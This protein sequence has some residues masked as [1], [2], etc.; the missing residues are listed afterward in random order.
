MKDFERHSSAM[1]KRLADY[2]AEHHIA[3]E[4]SALLLVREVGNGE[5]VGATCR[6]AIEGED[7]IV[8]IQT[9]HYAAKILTEELRKVAQT[10]NLTPEA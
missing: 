9:I 6:M 4:M 3:E 8:A 10:L 1:L 7:P 2:A 5:S